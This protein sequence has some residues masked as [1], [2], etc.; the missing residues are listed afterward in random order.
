MKTSE[1]YNIMPNYS[2]TDVYQLTAKR[3]DTNVKLGVFQS[4]LEAS[5]ASRH[6]DE[7]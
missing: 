7:L 2:R 1:S 5:Y 6:T 3:Y 4:Q